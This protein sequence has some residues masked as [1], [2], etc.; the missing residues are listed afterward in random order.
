LEKEAA[1]PLFFAKEKVTMDK[2]L[3]ERDN[4]KVNAKIGRR[5]EERIEE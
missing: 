3:R 5:D 4:M 1:S 2:P